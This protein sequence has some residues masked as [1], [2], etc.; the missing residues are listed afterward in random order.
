MYKYFKMKDI[1]YIHEH[2]C[3][4]RCF[5]IENIAMYVSAHLY[6]CVIAK[7]GVYFYKHVTSTETLVCSLHFG[8]SF[9]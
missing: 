2:I 8:F 4:C 5:Y 1:K 9:I 7:C 6:V 3:V